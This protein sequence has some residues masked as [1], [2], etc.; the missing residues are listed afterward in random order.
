MYGED[1]LPFVATKAKLPLSDGERAYLE[2]GSQAR[3]E[4]YR[5]A[6]RAKM[7]LLYADGMNASKTVTFP[8]RWKYGADNNIT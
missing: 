2:R 5:R 7:L 6:E 3:T 8:F 1:T 4:E